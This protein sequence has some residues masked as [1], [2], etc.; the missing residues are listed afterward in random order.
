MDCTQNRAS[1]AVW[2]QKERSAFEDEY[3]RTSDSTKAWIGGPIYG[4]GGPIAPKP[5]PVHTAQMSMLQ[6]I[7][8]LE[9]QNHLLD[10]ENKNWLH[11][12]ND[13][14]DQFKKLSAVCTSLFAEI[15]GLK[16][17]KAKLEAELAAAKSDAIFGNAVKQS[18]AILGEPDH[19]N[20][21]GGKIS[22][23]INNTN[24]S[25]SRTGLPL[26]DRY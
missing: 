19:S 24:F 10:E 6:K 4:S 9:R 5:V 2:F 21:K 3:P 17:E 23:A 12:F 8:D 20:T 7:T 16:I 15:N 1:A 25:N 26:H 11:M 13:K 22:R 18:F 14:S